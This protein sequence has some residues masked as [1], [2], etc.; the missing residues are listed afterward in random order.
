MR[1][2]YL[3]RLARQGLARRNE[4]LES[5]KRVNHTG[6]KGRT[7]KFPPVTEVKRGFI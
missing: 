2:E 4:R 3:E 7:Y 5:N 6:I 1:S